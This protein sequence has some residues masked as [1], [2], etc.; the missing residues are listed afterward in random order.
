MSSD[1]KANI[2]VDSTKTIHNTISNPTA[3]KKSLNIQIDILIERYYHPKK[4]DISYS[5]TRRT[6]I[7]ASSLPYIAA[8]TTRLLM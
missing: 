3:Q 5:R 7:E 6:K 2:I 1:T 4:I 8:H